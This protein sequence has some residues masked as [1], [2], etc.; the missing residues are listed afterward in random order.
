MDIK[1]DTDF[2]FFYWVHLWNIKIPIFREGFINY[3]TI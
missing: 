1:L 2:S 3:Y